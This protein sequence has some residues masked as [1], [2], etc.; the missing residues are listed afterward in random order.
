[1]KILKKYANGG[2]EPHNSFEMRRGKKIKQKGIRAKERG[3]PFNTGTSKRTPIGPGNFEGMPAPPPGTIRKPWKF[4]GKGRKYANGGKS[5]KD[6]TRRTG[7]RVIGPGGGPPEKEKGNPFNT[8]TGS[9]YRKLKGR[10]KKRQGPAR[11]GTEPHN[12]FEMK[13]RKY[14]G[15]GKMKE[16]ANGGTIGRAP[17]GQKE[18]RDKERLR[19]RLSGGSSTGGRGGVKGMDTAS[20]KKMKEARRRRSIEK[21][22]P[23]G[24]KGRKMEFGGVGKEKPSRFERKFAKQRGKYDKDVKKG[25]TQKAPHERTFKFRPDGQSVFKKRKL[26][27]VEHDHELRRRKRSERHEE[28]QRPGSDEQR[29]DKRPTTPNTED[30]PRRPRFKNGGTTG[31]GPGGAPHGT[32][33]RV[34][35]GQKD[36]RQR[37][38]LRRRI[39]QKRRKVREGK[40][41]PTGVK[42][43]TPA[44]MRERTKNSQPLPNEFKRRVDWREKKPRYKG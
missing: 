1:M 44:E 24:Y 17:G 21:A 8:G 41:Y 31:R 9:K 12:S 7:G 18:M 37:D 26:Y 29:P 38:R 32:V 5:T 23:G 33:G 25:R 15:G 34:P 36:E 40:K 3:N 35:G 30:G 10:L 11:G 2:T 4:K 27:N 43:S 6:D 39:A 22:N 42:E 14:M 20:F 16:Y 28:K 13:G 19:K